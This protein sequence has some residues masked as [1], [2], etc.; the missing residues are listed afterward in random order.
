MEA[1]AQRELEAYRTAV[2]NIVV[3][4]HRRYRVA[5]PSHSTPD[6]GIKG[7]VKTIEA[8]DRFDADTNT[9]TCEVTGPQGGDYSL[10]IDFANKRAYHGHGSPTGGDGA[11]PIYAIETMS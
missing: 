2:E 11:S 8:I 4:D 5:A 6:G 9:L 7:G 1:T 10:R 3:G